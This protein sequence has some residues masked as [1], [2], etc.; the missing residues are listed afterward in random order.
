MQNGISQHCALI[1][2]KFSCWVLLYFALQALHQWCTQQLAM[3]R[4]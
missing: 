1:L 3:R 4:K 2:G